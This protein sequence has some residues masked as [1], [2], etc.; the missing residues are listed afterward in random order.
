MMEV[1]SSSA[2]A[3]NP[4]DERNFKVLKIANSIANNTNYSF[5]SVTTPT[6]NTRVDLWILSQKSGGSGGATAIGGAGNLGLTWT[7]IGSTQTSGDF[8]LVHYWG[9]SATPSGTSLQIQH[10]VVQ[11]SC[12]I[13]VV[14]TSGVNTSTPAGVNAQGTAISTTLTL[15]PSGGTHRNL[16]LAGWGVNVNM[17]SSAPWPGF[18]PGAGS[19]TGIN[20]PGAMQDGNNDTPSNFGLVVTAHQY[21]DE[22]SLSFTKSTAGRVLGS[23]SEVV[24][25]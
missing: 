13:I 4:L 21:G 1:R 15:I 5:S 18:V 17:G 8:A 19:S 10:A 16:F 7:K 9:I 11:D 20:I 25:A 24:A 6:A 3:A 14:Q 22:T 12:D 2:P 23:A